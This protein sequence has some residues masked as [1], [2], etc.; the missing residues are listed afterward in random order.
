MKKLVTLMLLALTLN[1]I[2][3]GGPWWVKGTDSKLHSWTNTAKDFVD[4][5]NGVG[6]LGQWKLAK[7]RTHQYGF[8]VLESIN[9]NPCLG[10]VNDCVP[11]EPLYIAVDIRGFKLGMNIFDFSP[12]LAGGIHIPGIFLPLTKNGDDYDYSSGGV[13]MHFSEDVEG[14]KDL[15]GVGALMERESVASLSEKLVANYGLSTE[16]AEKVAKLSS[17]YAKLATKRSLTDSEMN[18][19]TQELMG[20]N[21]NEAQSAVEGT[22]QGDNTAYNRLIEKAAAKNGLSPEQVQSVMGDLLLK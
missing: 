4:E 21:Y 6:F 13:Q 14:G 15:E 16:R 22:M 11:S 10:L 2:G 20:M 18:Y 1:L 9:P 19:Y 7:A 5:L 17:S 12:S 8:I 3:C